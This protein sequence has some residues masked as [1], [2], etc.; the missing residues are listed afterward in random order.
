M[1]LRRAGHLSTEDLRFGEYLVRHVSD[2]RGDYLDG[3]G[4]EGGDDWVRAQFHAYTLSL[5]RTSLLP[6]ADVVLMFKQH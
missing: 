3:V 2:M 4:W 5:L 6:G 1:E